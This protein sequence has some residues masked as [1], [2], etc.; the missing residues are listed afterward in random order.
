M[1][2]SYEIYDMNGKLIQ[3]ES[4]NSDII[5]VSN[6]TSGNYIIIYTD[7]DHQNYFAQFVKQ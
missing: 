7:R 5:D 2:D 6:L 4:Y 1:I 3:K